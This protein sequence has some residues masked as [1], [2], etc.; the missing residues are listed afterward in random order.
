MLQLRTV[1]ALSDFH[2]L[3]LVLSVLQLV[4]Q[5][6]GFLFLLLHG[7]NEFLVLE[8]R[9]LHEVF[10]GDQLPLERVVLCTVRFDYLLVLLIRLLQTHNLRLKLLDVGLVGM[11]LNLLRF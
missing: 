1:L 9:P 2:A 10:G 4:L 8:R 6:G 5:V 3:R 7:A 11:F